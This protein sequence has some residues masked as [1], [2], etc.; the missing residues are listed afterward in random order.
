MAINKVQMQRGMSLSEFMRHYGTQAQ[1]EAAL[2]ALRWPQGFCCAGCGDRQA[3]VFRRGNLPYWQCRACRKQTSLTAGT[4]FQGTRL[5]LTK[6]FL[7]IY[8]MT[9]SKT[10]IAAL[11]LMRH[12]NIS[13]KAAWLLKHKLME[14]MFRREHNRPLRG[15]VSIDDAYLG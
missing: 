13:W 2:V 7:A 1:C 14:T 8:L 9:Q 12:L 10:Q 15:E 6:W 11:A 4:M 3:S 5:P